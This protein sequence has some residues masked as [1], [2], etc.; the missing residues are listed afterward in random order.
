MFSWIMIIAIA[1]VVAAWGVPAAWRR[2][3]G[4]DSRGDATSGPATRDNGSPQMAEPQ[5]PGA[6]SPVASPVTPPTAPAAAGE[7]YARRNSPAGNSPVGSNPVGSNPVGSNPVGSNPM[8]NGHLGGNPVGGLDRAAEMA[9]WN[10]D[11]IS[12]F[13]ERWRKVQLQFVDDPH[14]AAAEAEALI[15][16]VIESLATTVNAQK[17]KLDAWRSGKAED[18]EGLRIAVRRY[19]DFLDRVLG[20]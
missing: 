10:E 9:M 11:T 18:T 20:T 5:T 1:L 7:D 6:P 13:Q 15:T 2:F 17:S 4:D 16:D 19:R 3:T 14:D 8:G 12:G